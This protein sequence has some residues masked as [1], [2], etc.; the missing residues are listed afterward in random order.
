[1]PPE[2]E[3]LQARLRVRAGHDGS[4]VDGLGQAL[5]DHLRAEPS[6]LLSIGATSEALGGPSESKIKRLAK[7]GELRS[8]HIGRNRFFKRKDIDQYVEALSYDSD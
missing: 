5:H 3:E 4:C 7:S 1:M 8:V 6:L 2:I